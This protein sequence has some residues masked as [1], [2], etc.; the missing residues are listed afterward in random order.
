[1][2]MAMNRRTRLAIRLQFFIMV[3]LA[4]GLWT[5]DAGNQ[6]FMSVPNFHEAMVVD[7]QMDQT[8]GHNV[9]LFPAA[10]WQRELV[11]RIEARGAL[12]DA[13]IVG[14]LN[15]VQTAEGFRDLDARSPTF[16]PE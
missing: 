4:V 13:L 9:I 7:R 6:V 16:D 5:W 1:M 11:R 12:A 8:S 2:F 14:R 3:V 15:L 10:H